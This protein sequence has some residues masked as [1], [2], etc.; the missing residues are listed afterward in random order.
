MVRI[1]EGKR[2]TMQAGLAR[3]ASPA[4]CHGRHAT[5]C[6]RPQTRRYY[7]PSSVINMSLADSRRSAISG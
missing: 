5:A 1:G 2:G 4:S 7:A 6:R 3:P